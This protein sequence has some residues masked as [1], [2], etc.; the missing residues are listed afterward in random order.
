MAYSNTADNLTFRA[1]AAILCIT[2]LFYS[3]MMHKRS[4]IR[5]RL[6][7]MLACFTLVDSLTDILSYFVAVSFFS[8]SIK[9][10]L[11]YFF[12][13]VYFFT[14][15]ALIP[16]FVYYIV[17]ICGIRYKLNR[18]Q[19][20]II[21]IPCYLLE[22]LLLTNPFTDIVFSV[23]EN[24][25]FQREIGIYIAYAMSGLYLLLCVWLLIQY[26]FTINNMKKV[27][28]IYYLALV[29]LGTLIQLFYPYISCE[30][31][32]EGIGLMGIMIMIEKDDDRLEAVTNVYNRNA[33][34][35][36]TRN[37][38]SLNRE[39]TTVCVRLENIDILRKI[40]DHNKIDK[41]LRDIADFLMKPGRDLDVYYINIRA[42]YILYTGE[43]VKS[44]DNQI[45]KIVERFEKTWQAGNESVKIDI[46]L[47]CAKS[48]K[49]FDKIDDLFLLATTNLDN[50]DKKVLKGDDLGF[51]IRRMEVEKAIGR[52]ITEKGFKVT[53]RPLYSSDNMRIKAAEAVLKLID[54]ELGEVMPEEF[55][56]IAADV[57]FIEELQMQ[58]IES[59][60]K[61][62][63]SGVDTSD[64]QLDFVVIP[65]MSI[66]TANEGLVKKVKEYL[67]HYKLPSS[68]FA[69][70]VSESID[71]YGH[72]SFDSMIDGFDKMGIKLFI[73]DY[74]AAF[75]GL[76]P[77][78]SY[79]FDGA[80]INVGDIFEKGVADS[81]DI[82]LSNRTNM[83]RQLKKTII[84]DGIDNYEYYSKLKDVSADYLGGNLLSVPISKNELQNKFWH[85]EQLIISDTKVERVEED[86]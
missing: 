20:L 29:V 12:E 47:L 6:F 22:L 28:M 71:F 72:D 69:F 53:Y 19:N 73:N 86:G 74:E 78:T 70:E 85:G 65:V 26:W 24:F 77:S 43:Y 37:F 56:S 76:N 40:Y 42:F 59:V 84:I 7:A 27:A 25:V 50:N 39:F 5:N 33:F 60:C 11:I 81:S 30:L 67:G 63:N 54:S 49:P 52:G 68:L 1:A 3:T 18:I 61:F 35:Q 14:H 38:F 4:R 80:K 57:G 55:L 32:C 82:V 79:K 23:D 83:I 51:L 66:K 64:M 31:L 10:L 36:D 62:L 45:E 16:I 44:I 58:T 46:T 41:L 13:M 2:C 17:M 34:V 15:F 9:L 8:D 75:L 48:P 21:R